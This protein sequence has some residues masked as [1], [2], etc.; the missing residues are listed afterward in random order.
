M[1]TKTL[2]LAVVKQIINHTEDTKNSITEFIKFFDKHP[3]LSAVYTGGKYRKPINA[4]RVFGGYLSGALKIDPA[5]WED[6]TQTFHK[7]PEECAAIIAMGG[8]NVDILSGLNNLRISLE[9]SA[10]E[11][12]ASNRA[13]GKAHKSA[14]ESMGRARE[15]F[16]KAG[17]PAKEGV[18]LLEKEI[19]SLIS[20]LEESRAN[21]E[22]VA[23]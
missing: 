4:S 5:S 11:V 18:E 16:I 7:M 10:Q 13:N 1:S 17:L 22:K 3:D 14:L 8:D 12:V 15:A 20:L 19:E 2:T 23:A 6:L 9:A 21:A